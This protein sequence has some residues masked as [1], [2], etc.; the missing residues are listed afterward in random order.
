[1]RRLVPLG[2]PSIFRE[3]GDQGAVAATLLN[4][5][6]TAQIQGNL[7]LAQTYSEEALAR[8]RELGEPHGIAKALYTLALMLHYQGKDDRARALLEESL[9]IFRERNFNEGI[10]HNLDLLGVLASS[11]GDYGAARRLHEESLA[12]HQRS[13]D[14]ANPGC[15]LE[16][17]TPQCGRRHRHRGI[18]ASARSSVKTT[19]RTAMRRSLCTIWDWPP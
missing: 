14:K 1:M 10:A 3:A 19:G 2:K 12:I 17:A 13:G 7:T 5:A 4:L 6:N 16:S 15:A 8:F 11:A 18:R 9:S